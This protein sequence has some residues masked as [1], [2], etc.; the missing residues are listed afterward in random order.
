MCSFVD[1]DDSHEFLGFEG[2]PPQCVCVAPTFGAAYRRLTVV[3]IFGLTG[4]VITGFLGMNPAR[5]LS[6]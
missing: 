3:T 6:L 1:I 5:V 4:T 2:K